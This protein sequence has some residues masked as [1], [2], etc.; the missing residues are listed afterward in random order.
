MFVIIYFYFVIGI[1]FVAMQYV[2]TY[3]VSRELIAE[4]N[5][6]KNYYSI[7]LNIKFIIL[8]IFMILFWPIFSLIMSLV[9][10]YIYYKFMGSYNKYKT[11]TSFL[12]KKMFG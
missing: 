4:N 2:M 11:L 7:E 10:L 5:S 6:I 3:V 9:T 12:N 8:N 1:L